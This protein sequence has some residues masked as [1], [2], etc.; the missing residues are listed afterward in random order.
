MIAAGVSTVPV[1]VV[2]DVGTVSAADVSAAAGKP[3]VT[4]QAAVAVASD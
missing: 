3:A 2:S 1:S 4:V